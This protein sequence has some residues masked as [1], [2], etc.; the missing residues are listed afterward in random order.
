[1]AK[2]GPVEISPWG[3]RR[4]LWVGLLGGSFNPAHQGHIHVA[5]SALTRLGL[6]QVWLLVSPQNP[7]KSTAEMAPQA[8]RL[9]S[10]RALIGNHPRVIATTLESKLGTRYTADAIALLKRRFPHIHF[11]WIMGADNLAQIPQWNHWL[12]IFR[13]LPIAVADRP[14][15]SRAGVSAKA[16]KRF[17][18][19]RVTPRQIKTA[20]LPA[21]TFLHIRRHPASASSI[22]AQAGLSLSIPHTV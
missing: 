19:A 11:V 8:D 12:D 13:A 3:D 16:A 2:S 6:D 14:L 7:L 18:N 9:A 4:R 20:S 1:M 5:L 15:Y 10:A 22:R 21:W 17:A